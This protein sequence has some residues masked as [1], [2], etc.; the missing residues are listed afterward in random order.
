VSAVE[1]IE[2]PRDASAVKPE[3]LV[4][5]A[6]CG[7]AITRPKTSISVTGDHMHVV[8]NPAG[9]LFRIRCFSEAPGAGP[10]SP[11]FEDF[12]WFRGYAWR[13]GVCLSCR[14]HL[15]WRYESATG[16]MFWGLIAS[17]IEI[18]HEE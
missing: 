11:L 9:Y 14:A 4:L 10:A 13:I 16:S 15:G 1:S 2:R 6:A 3:S 7:Y 12:T 5:C 8:F 18:T 17:A